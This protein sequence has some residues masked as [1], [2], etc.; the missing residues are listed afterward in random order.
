MWETWIEPLVP[1][2]IPR[3][4]LATQSISN[5]GMNQQVEVVSLTSQL[6]KNQVKKQGGV[7]SGDDC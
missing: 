3:I 7:G 1:G 5:W 6:D 2:F 4:T